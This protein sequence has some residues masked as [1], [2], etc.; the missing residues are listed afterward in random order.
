M[1]DIDQPGIGTYP[2]PRSVLDMSA[3]QSVRA[4]AP[5]L[6]QHTDEVLGAAL[7]LDATELDKLRAD[8]TIG[9]APR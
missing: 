1:A 5:V 6:G 9:G 2:V 3:S 8:G 4:P 7:G